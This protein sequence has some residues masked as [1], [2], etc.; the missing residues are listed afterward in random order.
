MFV[1]GL[2]DRI[3]NHEWTLRIGENKQPRGSSG[4]G[5]VNGVSA[6]AASSF[7][8]GSPVSLSSG[9]VTSMGR[10]TGAREEV[11]YAAVGAQEEE[12]RGHDQDGGHG[13]KMEGR[14]STSSNSGMKASVSSASYGGGTMLTRKEGI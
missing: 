6:S 7:K 3:G 10:G 2:G 14:D 12:A 1:I 8:V 5:G 13:L 11:K 9:S 4:G